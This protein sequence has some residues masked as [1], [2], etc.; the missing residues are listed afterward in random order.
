MYFK[1]RKARNMLNELKKIARLMESSNEVP[2]LFD[3]SQ[4]IQREIKYSCLSIKEQ[5]E[6][7]KTY[8]EIVEKV[9]VYLENR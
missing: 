5:F 9:C 2:S 6:F 7:R 8:D 4:S 3:K 1:K